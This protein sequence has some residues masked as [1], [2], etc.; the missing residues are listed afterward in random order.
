MNDKPK[1]GPQSPWRLFGTGLEFAGVV[2]IFAYLGHLLDNRFGWEP[3]G[4]LTGAM[5]GLT[6]SMYNLIK[7]VNK[8]NREPP[9]K[10]HDEP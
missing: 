1:P 2:L 8:A 9:R 6:G 3:W 4:I 10:P 5:I 7:A